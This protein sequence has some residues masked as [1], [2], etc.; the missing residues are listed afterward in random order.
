MSARVKGTSHI[1]ETLRRLVI[2]AHATHPEWSVV[3]LAEALDIHQPVV[4]R[5]LR[6]T[7]AKNRIPHATERLI[8]LEPRVYGGIRATAR[9]YGVCVDTVRRLWSLHPSGGQ[10]VAPVY[11][12]LP[13]VEWAPGVGAKAAGLVALGVFGNVIRGGM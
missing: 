6:Y 9:K 5:A 3:Q 13:A 4:Y 10:G 1:S 12:P 8:L 2:A 7:Q 11:T